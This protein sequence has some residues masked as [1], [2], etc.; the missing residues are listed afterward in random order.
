MPKVLDIILAIVGEIP[1][2]SK[3]MTPQDLSNSLEAL[4]LLRDSDPK[5]NS[6][7]AAGGSMDDILRSAARRL[8]T[9]LPRLRGKDLRFT[10]PV[11][12]W[13]CAKAE[14]CH[15]ELLDSVARRLGSRTKLSAL[16]DFGVCALSWSYQVLDTQNDF[17]DFKQLLISEATSAER[18]LIEADVQSCELGR[19]G[20]KHS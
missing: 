16:P 9:L 5:V 13:A 3:D 6:F 1:V 19:F 10:V 14:V 17:K 15:G 20:W 18:W 7:L 2:K 12:V 8:S 4:I 11:V